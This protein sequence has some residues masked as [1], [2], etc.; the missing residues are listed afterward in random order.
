MAEHGKPAPDI[1]LAACEKLG[2]DPA[3]AIAVED[4]YNGIRAAHAAGMKPVMVPDI[5][6]PDDEMREKAV[7]ICRDLHEARKVIAEM[8]AQ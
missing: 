5:L 2:A 1:Y 8:L 7:H 6:P 4:S 3:E